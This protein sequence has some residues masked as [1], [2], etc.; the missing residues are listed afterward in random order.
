MGYYAMLVDQMKKENESIESIATVVGTSKTTVTRFLNQSRQVA[1][2]IAAS[3]VRHLLPKYEIDFMGNFVLTLT[4]PENI[5][6]SL[7]YCS[8]N[9]M[10]DQMKLLLDRAETDRNG[11]VQDAFEVYSVI[12]RMQTAEITAKQI[13]DIVRCQKASLPEH[14][15]LLRIIELCSIYNQGEYSWLMA[16]KGSIEEDLNA[17]ENSYLKSSFQ[18]RLNEVMSAITLRYLNQ[19]KK[20]RSIAKRILDEQF[21]SVSA[22]AS[23]YSR[24]SA[25]FLLEDYDRCVKYAQKAQKLYSRVGRKDVVN[26]LEYNT[27]FASLL[28]EKNVDVFVS[29][30]LRALSLSKAGK[31]DSAMFILTSM[32]D[33]EESM[34]AL[35]EFYKGEV[36]DDPKYYY[37]SLHMFIKKGD[38]YMAELSRIKLLKL[39]QPDYIVNAMFVA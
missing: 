26:I 20:A 36:T 38:R 21:A 28:W 3:I 37:N 9:R 31:T 22:K 8:V 24:V 7:E 39:G 34:S 2:E 19:P 18:C 1:P 17:L 29:Q 11:T 27:Q 23:A 14:Q 13:Y 15:L 35:R 25:S 4:R 33:K 6:K 5:R 12:Y 30:D 32:D 16:S 10:F